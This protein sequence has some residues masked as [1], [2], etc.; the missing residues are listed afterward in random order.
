MRTYRLA[1]MYLRCLLVVQLLCPAQ[2]C[3]AFLTAFDIAIA[4][5]TCMVRETTDRENDKL[6]KHTSVCYCIKLFSISR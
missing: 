2:C 6:L 5:Y 3:K 1:N 4:M